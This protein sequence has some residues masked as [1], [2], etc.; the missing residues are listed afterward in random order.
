MPEWRQAPALARDAAVV[1]VR[2]S[3]VLQYFDAERVVLIDACLD[4]VPAVWEET[5]L[6]GRASTAKAT[7]AVL[8]SGE[9]HE[10]PCTGRHVVPLP[11]DLREG[12]RLV[13][14]CAG[15]VTLREVRP[16]PLRT[17]PFADGP[18]A[19]GSEPVWLGSL[20]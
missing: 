15:M 7:T 20:A 4:S 1:V 8:L 9:S 2:I 17:S 11:A 19:T 16:Q 10:V 13:V 3:A 5:R 12:D 14:P 6:I 18:E